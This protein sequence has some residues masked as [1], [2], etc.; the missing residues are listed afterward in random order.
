[1]LTANPCTSCVRVPVFLVQ[2]G[3]LD[4][5]IICVAVGT[6]IADRPPQRSVRAELPHTAPPLD[7]S[8]ETYIRVGMQGARCRNPPVKD[9][10][11]LPPGHPRLLA[12]AT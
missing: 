3:I 12:P 7:T 10:A 4:L 11:D 6:V 8:V 2:Q 1:M 5:F 9:G